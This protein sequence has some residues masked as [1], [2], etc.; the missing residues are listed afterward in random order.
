MSV[1]GLGPLAAR[2]GRIAGHLELECAPLIRI[3]RTLRR[4]GR[5]AALRARGA[6]TRAVTLGTRERALRPSRRSPG[7]SADYILHTCIIC[8]PNAVASVPVAHAATSG[9]ALKSACIV[10]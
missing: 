6:V 4:I 7:P 9:R 1:A 8:I 5:G 3:Q 2:G 10:A